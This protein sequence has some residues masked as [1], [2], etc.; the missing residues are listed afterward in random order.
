[1]YEFTILNKRTNEERILFGHS[2]KHTFQ[3]YNLDMSDWEVIL[4]EY[5]D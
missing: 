2:I 4:V 5:I 3:K 1:M